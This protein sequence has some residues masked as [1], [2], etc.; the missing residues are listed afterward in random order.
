LVFVSRPYPNPVLVGGIVKVD[1][2]SVCPKNVRWA[3]YS[4]A[5]RKIGDWNV[6]TGGRKTT[7]S[8]NLTDSKGVKIA[9]GIYYMVF[10]PAGQ[11]NQKLSV[12]VLP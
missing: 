7:V 1:L 2:Q 8:W 5:Y 9:A 6:T 4:A 12:V 10:T 11:K 3:V